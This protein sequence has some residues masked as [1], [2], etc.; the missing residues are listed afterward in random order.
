MERFDAIVI[1][2]GVAGQTAAGELSAADKRV[3]VIDRREFG[4]TCAL[5]GCEP[6]KVLFTAAGS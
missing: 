6:K 2:T 5:R 3:A 4:G 1:G